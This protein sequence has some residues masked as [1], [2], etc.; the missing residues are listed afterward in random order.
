MLRAVAYESVCLE[1]ICA[2]EFMFSTNRKIGPIPRNLDGGRR[3]WSEREQD[4]EEREGSVQLQR[5]DCTHHKD[6]LGLWW[7]NFR[8]H[9]SKFHTN[10]L[11]H[12]NKVD[13]VVLWPQG[14]QQ[15]GQPKVIW[16]V[17]VNSIQ[18]RRIDTMM[19]KK[20]FRKTRL[21]WQ[22]AR[23]RNR[24]WPQ[25]EQDVGEYAFIS[26]WAVRSRAHLISRS[27]ILCPFLRTV[28]NVRLC[29]SGATIFT[30]DQ[31]YFRLQKLQ[32]YGRPMQ[33]P[34]NYRNES[35]FWKSLTYNK[36]VMG[37]VLHAQLFLKEK[38]PDA[39]K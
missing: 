13:R 2:L 9:R 30:D 32:D 39:S 16:S 27:S 17:L 10:H 4:G 37:R 6:I 38:C 11:C 22:D 3:C 18:R 29:R 31:D 12:R 7:N 26:T 36:H 8:L 5:K 15:Q 20:M 33:F 35:L 25:V 23:A 21:C 19:T 1:A 14:Q 24:P 34:S 28:C